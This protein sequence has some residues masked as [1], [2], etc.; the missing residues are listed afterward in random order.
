MDRWPSREWT[1]RKR[2][3]TAAEKLVDLRFAASHRQAGRRCGRELFM[4]LNRSTA[5]YIDCALPDRVASLW[6]RPG[7]LRPFRA[8]SPPSAI[9]NC[10]G[11]MC[12]KQYFTRFNP[13]VTAAISGPAVN[14]RLS[15]ARG[16]WK[17]RSFGCG[18]R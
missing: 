8:L 6:G 17:G 2:E 12:R 7:L 13:P 4:N 10:A 3:T 18:A 5:R 1:E 9:N 14:C 16:S 11:P 15:L